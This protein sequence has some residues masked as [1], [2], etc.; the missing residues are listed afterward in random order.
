[1]FQGFGGVLV[2]LLL[3]FVCGEVVALVV[4][5]CGCLMGVRG[6][7]MQLHRFFVLAMGHGRVSCGIGCA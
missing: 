4:R 2:G 7:V 6:L 3:E 5:G 1:V